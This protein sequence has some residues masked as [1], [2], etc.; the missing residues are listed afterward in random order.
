MN[1][2]WGESVA[3]KSIG[4]SEAEGYMDLFQGW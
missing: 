1:R 3:L 2:K 4:I